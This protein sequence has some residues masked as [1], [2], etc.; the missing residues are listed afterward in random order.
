MKNL[1]FQLIL[2]IDLELQD[3][4]DEK[5]IKKRIISSIE[6]HFYDKLLHSDDTGSLKIRATSHTN[7]SI[8]T[9]AEKITPFANITAYFS[10]DGPAFIA[11]IHG[12]G[13]PSRS[14]I[15]AVDLT[16]LDINAAL[17][18]AHHKYITNLLE[19]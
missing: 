10:S 11:N 6:D 5:D 14:S 4:E 16:L 13:D 19:D 1:R 12:N 17:R 9:K 18:E 8:Q 15:T 2:D 7:K 3:T